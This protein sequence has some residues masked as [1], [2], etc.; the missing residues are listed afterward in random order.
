MPDFD[1]LAQSSA[2]TRLFK[3]SG[4]ILIAAF[5]ALTLIGFATAIYAFRTASVAAERSTYNYRVKAAMAYDSLR[6]IK[7]ILV[8][9]QEAINKNPSTVP[10]VAEKVEKALAVATAATDRFNP[11]VTQ[12][13]Q[14]AIPAFSFVSA[15]YAQGSTSDEGQQR[16]EY[17]RPAIM[18]FVI[19]V[20]T[21]F[22]GV[23]VYMYLT[24]ADAE[25][26]KFADSMLRTIIGFYIGIVTGLLGIPPPA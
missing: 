17:I 22:G 11:P 2:T 24:T 19:I 6:D 7:S 9:A 12:K 13:E 25:R 5:L 10:D 1:V 15:A 4:I 26:I 20:I 3:R 8:E 18:I 14:S 21:A 23:C 16:P